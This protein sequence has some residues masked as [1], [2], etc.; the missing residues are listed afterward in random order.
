MIVVVIGGLF[1]LMQVRRNSITAARISYVNELRTAIS[2]YVAHFRYLLLEVSRVNITEN[3]PTNPDSIPEH[4]I[5]TVKSGES[6]SVQILLRLN[7]EEKEHCRLIETIESLETLTQALSGDTYKDPRKLQ[8]VFNPALKEIVEAGRVVI[9]KSWE[10][11][12]S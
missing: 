7:K 4:L 10:E 6:L 8:L 3:F 11:A 5:A 12:K 1:A 9:K 2:D